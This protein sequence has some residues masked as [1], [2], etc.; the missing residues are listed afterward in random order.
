MGSE[1]GFVGRDCMESHREASESPH[2]ADQSAIQ[3]QP[4]KRRRIRSKQ[5]PPEAYA[6]MD[7]IGTP[8]TQSAHDVEEPVAFDLGTPRSSDGQDGPNGETDPGS[9]SW[10]YRFY[11]FFRR[12][13]R[14]AGL[15]RDDDEDGRR[16]GNPLRPLCMEERY[17]QVT[18]WAR[19]DLF[20]PVQFKAE[21]VRFYAARQVPKDN[22]RWLQA[23]GVLLTWNGAWGE[24]T[25]EALGVQEPY[26]STDELCILLREHSRVQE[27]ERAFQACL[28]AWA[29]LVNFQDAAYSIEVCH[30]TYEVA[31][32]QFHPVQD[33]LARSR[34]VLP[35]DTADENVSLPKTPIRVHIHAFFAESNSEDRCAATL[36]TAIPGIPAHQI[37]CGCWPQC[38]DGLQVRAGIVLRAMSEKGHGHVWRDHLAIPGLSCQWRLALE[39]VA[40]RQNVRGKLSTGGGEVREELAQEFAKP[41]EVAPRTECCQHP[42]DGE[43][44][45]GHAARQTE[46][47][48]KGTASGSVVVIL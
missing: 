12:W 39:F 25:F 23:K 14:R 43:C 38:S 9:P 7:S 46:A 29:A 31:T 5:T 16:C 41:G 21:V 36:R 20:A 28:M 13:R 34:M 32:H 6:V 24:F 4:L 11:G 1:S 8:S 2:A 45:A 26:P 30:R 18:K 19:E 22:S 33:Q 40:A 48:P 37:P 47:F 42:S 27:L 15:G 35:Q 44:D 3:S 10:R 17:E